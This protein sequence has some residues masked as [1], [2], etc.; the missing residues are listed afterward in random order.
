[1]YLQGGAGWKSAPPPVVYNDF[2]ALI[3]AS[4]LSSDIVV[5]ELSLSFCVSPT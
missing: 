1:M 2:S 4:D 3:A 5:V